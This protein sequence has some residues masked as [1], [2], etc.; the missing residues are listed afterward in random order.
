MRLNAEVQTMTG[1]VIGRFC[2]IQRARTRA[3]AI[4]ARTQGAWWAVD[5]VRGLAYAYQLGRHVS[6]VYYT[7]TDERG[8]TA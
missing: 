2:V 8:R 4:S 3:R 6:T 7:E 5:K 1:H